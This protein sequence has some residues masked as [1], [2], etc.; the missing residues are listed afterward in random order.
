M[1]NQLDAV[2]AHIDADIDASLDRLFDLLRI[3]S[4]STD[5]AHADDCRRAADWLVK[6]VEAIGFAA[7]LIDTPEAPEGQP[8][9][10]AR[11]QGGAGRKVLFYGHY[12]VQ[13]V[14]P[15]ELWDNP[16]FEPRV[17]TA[18]D[19]AKVIR[20]RGAADDK[21]QLFTF[22]EACRAWKAVT[23]GL[24]VEVALL[25]EGEEESGSPS[26]NPFLARHGGKLDADIALVCDTSMWDAS[27]PAVTTALRGLV[28]EE[29]TIHAANRDLHS[30]HYGSAARNP[31]AVL[32]RILADLR[33]EN[34]GVALPGF[35]DG[36]AE[37][38]AAVKQSWERLG[39]D[40]KAFLGEIGLA[41]PAGERDRS[42]LEQVWAR[43]TAE[44]NGIHGG[45]T[46]EGFKTVIPAI[47]Q[48]KVSFRLV[49]GQDPEK[50]RAAFRAHVE[51]R[52]PA[53]CSV[54]FSPHGGGPG[55]SLNAEGPAAQ[56]TARALADEWGKPAALIAMGGSIPIVGALKSKLDMDA[57]LVGFGLDSD[58][59]HSP[60]EQYRFESFH[61]GARS[62]ARILAALAQPD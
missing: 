49:P 56:A 19:G 39:F 3:P 18:P 2:L 29:I 31:I 12:D 10:V 21:G 16:P 9:L 30:G 48:A 52:L 61:R 6:E 22:V 4:I 25:F 40:E 15:L 51:A 24:P 17:E 59:I 26:M 35:Y 53:D 46:G 28:G 58:N 54:T 37:T 13:P 34:G 62:W 42:V 55:H 20:A 14:D 45:Y 27:T 41:E 23:G 5:P 47:A 11:Q 33:D 36:V 44:I 7:E 60:N 32:T 1:Q 8:M 43:P 57:L 38:P 50:I